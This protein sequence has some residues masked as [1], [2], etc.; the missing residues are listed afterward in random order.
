MLQIIVEKSVSQ[1][2]CVSQTVVFEFL[3]E[4]LTRVVPLVITDEKKKKELSAMLEVRIVKQRLV[5]F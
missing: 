4:N 2:V 5:C 3:W 1:T